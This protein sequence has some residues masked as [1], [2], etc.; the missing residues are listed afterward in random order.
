MIWN[1]FVL[2]DDK[3]RDWN[4]VLTYETYNKPEFDKRNKDG[5]W[6]YATVN[7]F[8][9]TQ[10]D[11]EELAKKRNVRSVTR[12]NIE[13]LSKINWVFGDLDVAK[14]WDSQTQKDKD[15][16]K[17][18]IIEKLLEYCEPSLIVDTRNWVQPVWKLKDSNVSPEYQ[19]RCINVINWIIWWSK[20]YWASWDQVKDVTRVLRMPWYYHNK[21]EPYM[22]SVASENND[23]FYTIEQLEE[24][25][26][27]H[28][29]EDK[30]QKEY[31][32]QEHNND[33][34][35]N[36]QYQEVLSLDFKEV[37]IRAFS[38]INR[39]CSFDKQWRA[40]IDWRLTWTFVWKKN[41][42]DYLASTSHEPFTWNIIT[43]V[44]D[45]QSISNKEAYKWIL[46]EFNIKSESILK[47]EKPALDKNTNADEYFMT[48]WDLIEE[49]KERRQKL[50]SSNLCTYWIKVLDKY[51]YWILPD[52]LV[53][54]GAQTWVGKSEIAYSIWISNAMNWKKV[55]L[56]A[57]EWS[58]DEIALRHLQRII[59][60]DYFKRHNKVITTWDYRFNRVDLNNYE[61][62]AAKKIDESIKKNLLIF[63]KKVIPDLKVIKELIEKKKDEVDMIIIDH[64]HYISF[65]WESENKVIWDIMRELKT[66]TDII[67]KPVILISHMRKPSRNDINNDP[68]EYDL[69]WSGNIAKE[70]TTIILLAKAEKE[71][72]KYYQE[73]MDTR[74]AWTKIISPK[75]RIWLWYLSVIWIYDK[76]SK[77]YID[78]SFEHTDESVLWWDGDLVF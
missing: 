73:Y 67:K 28:L 75:S 59:F 15:E 11:K 26:L 10:I 61:N 54:I 34:N 51:L 77:E 32:K 4:Y 70:A 23:L 17:L 40:I 2:I 58:M 68:T 29:E 53:V 55:A 47:K 35:L 16:N 5:W 46:D 25:F 64:L 38:S 66:M 3:K 62:E 57:L 18:T 6:I 13:F 65:V 33:V 19:L 69:H 41:N 43:A 7:D 52:E 22:C 8:S 37:M 36:L 14:D 1:T 63:N 9:A 78:E 74:Y 12:R 44:A 60:K 50:N 71:A 72:M 76:F 30:L 20:K 21:K 31:K 42:K 48:Y 45:I 24:K 39:N 49:S 56:F 27:E